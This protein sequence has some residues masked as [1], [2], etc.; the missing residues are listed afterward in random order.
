[1]NKRRSEETAEKA[2]LVSSGYKLPHRNDVYFLGYL[3]SCNFQRKVRI[4]VPYLL[5]TCL[6]DEISKIV[7]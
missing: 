6:F 5:L 3:I 1:M 2:D 7:S 4:K